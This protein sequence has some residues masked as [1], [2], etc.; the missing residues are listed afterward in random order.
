MDSNKSLTVIISPKQFNVEVD[1]NVYKTLQEIENSTPTEELAQV[2]GITDI[3]K[4]QTYNT[5]AVININRVVE[6]RELCAIL[7]ENNDLDTVVSGVK[8]ILIEFNNTSFVSYVVDELGNKTATQLTDLPY[9]VQ[10]E[11]DDVV[12]SYQTLDDIK[13]TIDYKLYKIIKV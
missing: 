13:L 7:I 2:N 5:T 3:N 1:E 8:S 9:F 10:I 6:D 12:L 4:Q 11:G